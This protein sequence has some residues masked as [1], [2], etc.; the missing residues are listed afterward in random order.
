MFQEQ[1]FLYF[2]QKYN[3]KDPRVFGTESLT[4]LLENNAKL[5]SKA[6]PKKVGVL[7][8]GA[9][10]DIILVNYD[11]PTPMNMGNL[12][13]QMVFG[14]SGADVHTT[15]VGGRTV[16]KNRELLTIDEK[17]I[18]ARCRERQPGIHERL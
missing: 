9:F 7:E 18:F 16:V 6:F 14:M 8:P 5:A 17:E 1:K 13:W 10:A 2:A 11:N 12:P 15:I 4:T 3:Y